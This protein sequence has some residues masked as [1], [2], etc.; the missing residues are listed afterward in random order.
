MA[1]AKLKWERLK[2]AKKCAVNLYWAL[3]TIKMTTR[4]MLESFSLK[5]DSDSEILSLH[6]QRKEKVTNFTVSLKITF[7]SA[8]L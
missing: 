5:L 2:I 6:N 8:A 3:V 4:K 1:D 7:L